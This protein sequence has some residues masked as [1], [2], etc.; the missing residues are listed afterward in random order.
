MSRV[1]PYKTLLDSQFAQTKPMVSSSPAQHLI[2]SSGRRN[3]LSLHTT[4]KLLPLHDPVSLITDTI[5]S[6]IEPTHDAS[7]VLLFDFTLG[8]GETG[9]QGENL[10]VWSIVD[11]GA[12]RET[13]ATRWDLVRCPGVLDRNTPRL[14]I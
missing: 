6:I 9:R 8:R 10:G 5:K 3:V 4:L 14:T 13:K 12:M 1:K 11:K 7:E 2:Y